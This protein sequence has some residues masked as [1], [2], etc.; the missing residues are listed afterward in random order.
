MPS[1]ESVAPLLLGHWL[2]RN[3]P[4]G[5][6]GGPIVEVEAYL[7]GHDPASHAFGGETN[8]NRVMFGPPGRAYVY[9]I[10][11]FHFCVN[12]VCRRAGCA[13]AV[14]I[15]ALEAE[16]GLVTM[17]FNRPVETNF[18]LTNGPGKLCAALAIDR[19]LD[20]VDLCDVCSPLFIARN[21]KVARF[22]V[23]RGPV[24]ASARIGL[25]K[26]ADLPL[27][28]YLSGSPFLSRR[29]RVTAE[30]SSG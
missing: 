30:P 26:A 8:R 24:V 27:R 13:E 2:I 9:L 5:P 14:L 1:A 11:G 25:T 4:S 21:P 3:L 19:K 28:F 15:R 20:G 18:A 22:R 23:Q 16:R 7:A 10:Y 12:V 6:C 29:V 17:R